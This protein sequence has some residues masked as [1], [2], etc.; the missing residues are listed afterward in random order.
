MKNNVIINFGENKIV[1]SAAFAK[2][3]Q[4]AGS[5]EYN[6]LQ[7]YRRDYPTFT[8]TVRAIRKN[9]S[10]E[11]YRGL[12][13][14]YMEEYIRSHE[15]EAEARKEYTELK[16]LAACH[17]IRYP[18]IKQWFLKKYPEVKNFGSDVA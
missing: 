9:S 7:Q 14:Q 15:G 10:K 18:V 5:A 16:T 3:A 2:K 6:E 17:S 13:Y 4:I 11:C 8:V 1:M 12:T